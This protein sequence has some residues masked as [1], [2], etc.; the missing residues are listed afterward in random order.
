[1]EGRRVKTHKLQT[2]LIYKVQQRGGGG[3]S[4]RANLGV[5]IKVRRKRRTEGI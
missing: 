4:T 5:G 3:T 2:R 1:M